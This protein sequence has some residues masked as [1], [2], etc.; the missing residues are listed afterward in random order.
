MAAAE[1]RP[2][3]ARRSSFSCS[4]SRGEAAA[5]PPLAAPRPPY[6]FL[7]YLAQELRFS[8]CS[9]T[10]CLL[11]PAPELAGEFWSLSRCEERDRASSLPN[12]EVKGVS[13]ESPS[14]S[15]SSSA[16][17]PPSPIVAELLLLARRAFRSFS[18]A[19]LD[20]PLG[21]CSSP[22]DQAIMTQV[23]QSCYLRSFLRRIRRE[24]VPFARQ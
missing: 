13:R 20:R 5:P 8:S 6:L 18:A 15:S 4:L 1:E 7:R 17:A 21:Y 11:L 9:L 14:S 2:S 22:G 23:I 10:S 12:R 16:P 19:Y 3:R 24:L